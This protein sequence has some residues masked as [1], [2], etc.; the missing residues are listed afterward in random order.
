MEGGLHQWNRAHDREFVE[1]EDVEADAAAGANGDEGETMAKPSEP[2][3]EP[4][5][6]LPSP[7]LCRPT[8]GPAAS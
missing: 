8:A 1:W 4:G 6:A 3:G 5:G 7:M 2:G